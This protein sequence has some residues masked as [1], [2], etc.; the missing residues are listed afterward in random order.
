MGLRNLRFQFVVII[1]SVE[2]LTMYHFSSG[3][4]VNIRLTVR[5]A[6]DYPVDLYYVMDL[7]DSMKDDLENLKSLATKIGTLFHLYMKILPINI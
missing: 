7:S 3:K 5:P 6:E 4:P 1:K 2:I